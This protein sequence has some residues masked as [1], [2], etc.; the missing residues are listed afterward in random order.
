MSWTALYLVHSSTSVKFVLSRNKFHLALESQ[1]RIFFFLKLPRFFQKLSFQLILCIILNPI[2][3]LKI[4]LV[5][6]HWFPANFVQEIE[7]EGSNNGSAEDH[8]LEATG[9]TDLKP[10][11]DLQKGSID[12]VGKQ[13]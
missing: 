8:E 4:L 12:I 3:N 6:Q 2:K 1:F 13:I 11:G 10:L 5:F 7:P 9:A